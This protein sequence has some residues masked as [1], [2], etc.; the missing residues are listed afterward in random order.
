MTQLFGG[1]KAAKEAAKQQ[2]MQQRQ[3][4]ADLARQQASADMAGSTG[5]AKR[6]G[7]LL[8]FLSGSGQDTLG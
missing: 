6:G 8:T 2:K 4:L 1:N 5:G 3:S 7:K